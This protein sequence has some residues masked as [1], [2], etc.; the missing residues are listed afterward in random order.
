MKNLPLMI[1]ACALGGAICALTVTD[2]ASAEPRGEDTSQPRVHELL[3]PGVDGMLRQGSR[4]ELPMFETVAKSTRELDL[5]RLH[6]TLVA[7]DSSGGSTAQRYFIASQR[8]V[9]DIRTM[10]HMGNGGSGLVLIVNGPDISNFSQIISN[11]KAYLPFHNNLDERTIHFDPP[12]RIEEGD[13]IIAFINN[14]GI[15]QNALCI[16]TMHGTVPADVA[17]DVMVID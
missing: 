11:M 12:I 16:I 3:L 13:A 10:T 9:M 14:D 4:D 2:M 6:T 1:G 15:T 7:D 5:G 17:G 8:D